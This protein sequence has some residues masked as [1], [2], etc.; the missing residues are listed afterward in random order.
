[1]MKILINCILNCITDFLSIQF[2][3]WT[4]SFLILIKSGEQRERAHALD[5]TSILVLF[6]GIVCQIYNNLIDYRQP[7]IDIF[8]HLLHIGNF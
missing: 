2:E 7:V 6:I 5:L 4:R 3:C 8:E 1:M